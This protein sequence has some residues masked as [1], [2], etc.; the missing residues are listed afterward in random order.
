MVLVELK[1][2]TSRILKMLESIQWMQYPSRT[3][4]FESIQNPRES[5]D[6]YYFK[7]L[8]PMV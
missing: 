7:R 8:L 2:E 4:N 1:I 3:E 6:V 5:S